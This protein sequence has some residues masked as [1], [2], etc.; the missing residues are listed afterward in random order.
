VN[1]FY[2][3][4]QKT[5]VFWRFF[6]IDYIDEITLLN[7]FPTAGPMRYKITITITATKEIIKAYSKN[8]CPSL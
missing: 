1:G 8:P 2:S 6:D 4:N 5:S 7:M 3:L